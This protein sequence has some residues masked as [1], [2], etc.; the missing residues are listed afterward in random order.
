MRRWLKGT[1]LV[2][3]VGVALRVFF[4]WFEI[5]GLS[6]LD[7]TR[8][9]WTF[10]ST[11][12][13]DWLTLRTSEPLPLEW[14]ENYLRKAGY[15]EVSSADL[16]GPGAYEIQGDWLFV[17]TRPFF[18]PSRS[19]AYQGE[20]FLRIKDS[21]SSID[22]LEV[23]TDGR[24]WTGSD[25]AR[26]EPIAIAHFYDQSSQNREFILPERI[27]PA[28]KNA[29]VAIEDRR[30]FSHGA[31][32]IRAIGR[33]AWDDVKRGRA[34]E[35]GST[36]TQQ[37]AKNIFLTREKTLWRKFLELGVAEM[38]E[39]RYSKPEILGMYLNQV[40]L[41]QDGAVSVSGVGAAAK[42]YFNKPV[43]SLNL[44]ECATLAGMVRSPLL[45]S[46]LVD[47]E[48][49]R[50]RRNFV[51][52]RMRL[53]GTV[54]PEEA[55]AAKSR[56][57]GLSLS[58]GRGREMGLYFVDH[59]RNLL[60]DHYSPAALTSQGMNIFTT[61]D[62][63]LQEA[64]ERAL[65]D[66]S[67]EV[68]LVA[69]DPATGFV[70]A[71]VGGRNHRSSSFNRATQARRQPGSAFKPF[72][73]GAALDQ[74]RSGGT[75]WTLASLL[76]DSTFTASLP[77]QPELWSPRN[78]DG[79]FRGRV[80]VATSL[81]ESLNVPTA[82][83]TQAISPSAVAAF[84][85]K[86]GIES[87]LKAVLSIG[88]G[89][90]EVTLLELCSAYTGFA[91]G[92]QQSF[93]FFI[94]SVMG[95]D[96]TILEEDALQRKSVIDPATAYLVTWTLNQALIQGTARAAVALGM[97][98][99]FAGKTGTTEAGHD[100]W[101]IGYSP[102]ILCGVWVGDDAPRSSGLS[103]PGSALPR[104]MSFMKISGLDRY[105]MPFPVP[106][107]IQFRK[108]DESSGL[109]ARSGCPRVVTMPFAGDTV[110]LA[111]CAEHPGGV[112]G[113]LRRWFGVVPHP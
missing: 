27:P 108:V 98:G 91:E 86:A 77:G 28:L 25:T 48:R 97:T 58:R 50:S 53:E 26:L 105:S 88:L 84:A 87:P 79:I 32:D 4:L 57:L 94:K 102:E 67:H 47:P 95:H 59:V 66:S 71:L 16:P 68:A 42:Y 49:A 3:C 56:P 6:T 100:A 44:A 13:S 7:R 10:P 43:S 113:L 12:Y 104:W 5:A 72:V 62:P 101:F 29:V 46:P 96:G 20:Q 109:L 73:Y 82:R 8:Q 55:E 17:H 11:V 2:V 51:L 18:S 103:G 75:S 70:R 14:F 1:A 111:Y 110:P 83:L 69:L 40:Y 106:P 19:E 39:L 60:L 37:L 33:A 89:T 80:T 63:F 107:G 24:S 74:W 52:D 38:I 112:I 41:G 92:G 31:W 45:Y 23:S 34:A 81:E 30:F 64:A 36:L 76:S 99:A 9:G 78:Y 93:P 61:L 22:R 65:Q 90:N 35:G 54:S 15:T 85:R 21:S